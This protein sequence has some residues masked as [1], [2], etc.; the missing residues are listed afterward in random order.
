MAALA[1]QFVHHH[2]QAFEFG[3]AEANGIINEG[4]LLLLLGIK[5]NF[6]VRG[7]V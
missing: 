4:L 1:R 5:A 2:Q 6:D 7:N 3:F